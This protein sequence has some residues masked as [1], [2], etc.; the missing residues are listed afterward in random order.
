MNNK[1]LRNPIILFKTFLQTYFPFFQYILEI[2]V[3][4]GKKKSK[5]SPE[6]TTVSSRNAAAVSAALA[7]GVPAGKL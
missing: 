7:A 1:I 5:G 3:K 4:V 6:K 2:V